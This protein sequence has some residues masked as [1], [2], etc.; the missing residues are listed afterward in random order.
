MVKEDLDSYKKYVFEKFIL[1]FIILSIGFTQ[2]YSQKI[3]ILPLGD[4]ITRDSF[5]ANP[6][7]DS[8]LTGYRQPLW[9]LLKS[10]NYPI[11]FIGSDSSGYGA[12]PKF[13]PD[14]AG[15]G[16]YTTQQLLNLIMTGIDKNNHIITPGP[17]LNYYN[18]N[19][20]L[21]HIGTNGLDTT[22]AVLDKLLNCIDDF[23]DSTNSLIWV[24]LAKIINKVPYSITTSI[25]NEN[26]ERMAEERIK[27]G[28]HIKLVDMEKDAGIIYQIDTVAPYNNGDIYDGVHPNNRGYAKM[29][30]LFNDT[31][32]VLLND[33]VPV[34]LTHFSFVVS[35]DSVTLNW[36][37]AL[38]LNN[39]GFVIERSSSNNI[40]ENVGFV[41]GADNSYK[42]KQYKFTDTPSEPSSYLYRLRQIGNNGNSKYL[43][44]VDVRMNTL[45]SALKLNDDIPKEFKLDQNYPNPFNPTT[46]I[47]YSLPKTSIV[48][49]KVYN[50]LGQLVSSLVNSIEEPGVYEKVWDARGYAS[51]VYFY[52]MNIS[53]DN[54]SSMLRYTKKM[55][56]VK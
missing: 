2:T 44:Q 32:S 3:K 12:F 13:D 49:L 15:F 41:A 6:R 10:E 28:D 30:S 56:L 22:T 40:W 48:D 18:P 7:P 42:I 16:G 31:L 26:I 21:L 47:R 55:I 43:A 20:I 50:S 37:T 39:Y 8:I 25:Y 5:R 53:S 35:K 51:G 11:D 9:L 36:Q 14:N 29:A 17:Y 52:V 34:E 27:N 4:S 1:S 23:E 33:I 46:V 54:G 45:T 24:V 19:V 38:E